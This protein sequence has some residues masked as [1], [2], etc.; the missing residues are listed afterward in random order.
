ML[1]PASPGQPPEAGCTALG[2]VRRAATG[3]W[4]SE[5][6]PLKILVLQDDIRKLQGRGRKVKRRREQRGQ[7]DPSA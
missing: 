4:D 1:N 6:E 2:I 7:A 3:F 5:S